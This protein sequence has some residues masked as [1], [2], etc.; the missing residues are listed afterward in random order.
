MDFED[1]RKDFLEEVKADASTSG[2]GSV[3]TFVQTASSYMLN[4]DVFPDAITP[5]YY[6]GEGKRHR[7]IRVDGYLFDPA[8]NTMNLFIA[9][10]DPVQRDPLMT[11]TLAQ[12]FFNKIAY[13]V[14]EACGDD[15]PREIEPSSPASDL[16]DDIRADDNPIAKYRFVILSTR[17]MGE[18]AIK[19]DAFSLG[20]IP[21]EFQIWD[22]SRIFRVCCSN[23]GRQNIELNF[24]DY[25]SGGIPC[26]EAKGMPQNNY[27]SYLCIIPGETLAQIYDDIGS[28]LLEG[29]VRS[30]LSTKVAVNKKIRTTIL[31]EPEKFFAYNNG[32]AATAMNLQFEQTEDGLF[33]TYAEDFQIINGG[34]TT[35]SLSNARRKDRADL[36]SIFVQM[37]LT[38]IDSSSEQASDLIRNI[39]KS[40]N[41][42]NK[43]SDADFFSTHPFHVRMEQLSRRIFAPAVNGQQFETH[44]FYERARGQY[45]QMQMAMTK[46]QKD[47]FKAQNPKSQLIT[48]TDL[49]K[50]RNSWSELPHV[51]SKGAQTNF[52]KFAEI[53]N[54]GWERN[55]DYY[56]EKY[57]KDSMAISKLFRE[58]ESFVTIQ[59]WYEQGYRANIVTY[60]ISLFHFL[61]KKLAPDKTFDLSSIWNKQKVPSLIL[62][63]FRKIT[64]FVNECITDPG[65]ETVNV[66]QWCKRENCWKK[67]KQA[68]EQEDNLLDVSS[69]DLYLLSADDD[70]CEMRQA[71]SSQRVVSDVEAQTIILNQ[72]AAFWIQLE[73]FI[74]T[75]HLGSPEMRKALWPA[76]RIPAKIPTPYQSKKLLE[77]WDEAKAEGFKPIVREDGENY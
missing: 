34:Q 38:E 64:A 77:L 57:F 54:D 27:K 45:F 15:L 4:S 44:W 74:L 66:T 40:S 11:R 16:V 17:D 39:S 51:V 53:I 42:Q 3:A 63:E 55:P 5:A 8:D 7:K 72:G 75:K 6:E 43:V 49:A 23:L 33:I 19:F 46:A 48:K 50:A 25:V 28:Q 69:I 71:K 9:D 41:S 13:F 1:F 35:A 58:L 18:R 2:L 70:R 10:Y 32:I 60:S 47:T 73:E 31:Q 20:N 14:E 21:V 12:G 36:S 52:M 59:P 76:K 29:N 67:I 22:L 65:R 26:I 62:D 24:K 61:L 56:N 37:K 30:F 68:S